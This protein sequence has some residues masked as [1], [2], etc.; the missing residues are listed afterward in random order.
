MSTHNDAELLHA[1][2]AGRTRALT[3]MDIPALA[4]ILHERYRYVDSLGRDLSR[5][6]Y[7]QSRAQGEVQIESQQI[8]SQAIDHLGAGVAMVTLRTFEHFSYRGERLDARYQV[9]HICVRRGR[10][11]LFLFGQSTAIDS[12]PDETR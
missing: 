8:E 6:D 5:D 12:E 7:L 11:W 2:V 3:Q 9:V 10:E 4:A 1:L